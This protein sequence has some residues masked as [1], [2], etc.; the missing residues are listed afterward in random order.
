MTSLTS[1]VSP[2]NNISNASNAS[3][4]VSKKRK[5]EAGEENEKSPKR[6]KISN[7]SMLSQKKIKQIKDPPVEDLLK[8]LR[9]SKTAE[10][11][12][13]EAQKA[14][15][16]M[17]R[18]AI[19]V[20]MISPEE[21]P[22]N[23]GICIYAPPTILIRSNCT[24]NEKLTT[25]VFE[26]HNMLQIEKVT[27]WNEAA[28]KGQIVSKEEYAEGLERIEYESITAYTKTM[29]KCAHE[30][31]NSSLLLNKVF[32]PYDWANFDEYLCVQKQNGHTA[33]YMDY[34]QKK[35]ANCGKSEKEDINCSQL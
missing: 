8:L 6:S 1:A 19:K 16:K 18:P 5:S 29:L 34:F 15:E 3:S 10:T 22:D 7:E 2:L 14:V 31:W 25:L 21:L 32:N 20:G 27:K 23:M 24:K 17:Q 13:N 9:T 30:G 33:A 35:Y 11:L 28:A 26:L 12:W 4:Q